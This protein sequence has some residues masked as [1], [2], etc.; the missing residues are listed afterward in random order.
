M[1]IT[2]NRFL[3]IILTGLLAACGGGGSSSSGGN[4]SSSD[5]DSFTGVFIDS[6][7]QNLHY[8]TATQSGTTDTFGHFNYKPGEKIIFS[9]GLIDFPAIDAQST[10][11]PWDV[12][13]PLSLE[14]D[15]SYATKTTNVLRLLQTLDVDSDPDNGIQIDDEAHNAAANLILRFDS[16]TFD[17]DVAALITHSGSAQTQLIS[18]DQ[19]KAHFNITLKPLQLRALIGAWQF[20]SESWYRGVT[21]I[22]TVLDASHYVTIEP[23]AGSCSGAVQFGTFI[24]DPLYSDLFD[25]TFSGSTPGA[26]GY[27]NGA[28]SSVDLR[29]RDG[30]MIL[31]LGADKVSGAKILSTENSILGSWVAQNIGAANATFV[32]TF[33]PDGTYFIAANGDELTDPSG[34][35]G[36]E[37]GTYTWNGATGAITTSILVGDEIWR[38]H[39]DM[40]TFTISHHTRSSPNAPDGGPDT[41]VWASGSNSIEFTHVGI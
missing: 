24:W 35:D 13:A 28:H 6:P 31:G 29:I 34:Q 5:E 11:T 20:G 2:I 19:A 30:E 10:L 41:A 8:Q 15:L 36:Y 9:I 18:A 32:L 22:I 1:L 38:L 12:F 23:V 40:G 37:K 17:S 3:L 16:V 25:M 7:V 4:S 39:A 27:F 33:L 21:S 14:T 26:C